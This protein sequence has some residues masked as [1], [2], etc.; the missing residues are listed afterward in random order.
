MLKRTIAKHITPS[1]V[2]RIKNHD[3]RKKFSKIENTGK[4]GSIKTLGF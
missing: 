2:F 4:K 1:N 3:P